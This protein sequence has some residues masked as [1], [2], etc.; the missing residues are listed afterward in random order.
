[1]QKFHN[2]H[3]ILYCYIVH[4]TKQNLAFNKFME[5]NYN[6]SD[7]IMGHDSNTDTSL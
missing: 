7:K 5:K 4:R 6:Q 1:M 2:K 3:H